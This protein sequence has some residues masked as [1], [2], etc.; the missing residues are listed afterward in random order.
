MFPN[1]RPSILA[2]Y[3]ESTVEA[4]PEK[5]PTVCLLIIFLIVGWGGWIRTSA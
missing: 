2:I 1:L 3:S 4:D 5:I